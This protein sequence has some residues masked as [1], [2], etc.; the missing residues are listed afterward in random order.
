MKRSL[1]F[2]FEVKSVETETTTS[3]KLPHGGKASVEQILGSEERNLKN[4][5]EIHI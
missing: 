5:T 2:V 1:P 3:L 4:S